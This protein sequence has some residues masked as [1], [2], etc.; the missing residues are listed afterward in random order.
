[1]FPPEIPC[2]YVSGPPVQPPQCKEKAKVVGKCSKYNG[3]PGTCTEDGGEKRWSHVEDEEKFVQI[4]YFG[5]GDSE[6]KN[7]LNITSKTTR[8]VRIFACFSFS[9]QSRY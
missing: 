6:E 9:N 1:M 8:N 5:C 7:A 4:E 2:L 3:P